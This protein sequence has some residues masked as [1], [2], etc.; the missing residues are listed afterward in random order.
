MGGAQQADL[1][2]LRWPSGLEQAFEDVSA[3]QVFSVQEGL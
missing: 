1:V 3:N 2:V